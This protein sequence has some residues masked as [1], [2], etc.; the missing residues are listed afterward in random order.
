MVEL[1]DLDMHACPC[2][3]VMLVRH[4]SFAKGGTQARPSSANNALLFFPLALCER[5]G[6]RILP[7]FS[8]IMVEIY[9]MTCRF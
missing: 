7:C 1:L 8:G 3:N 6:A 2:I 4:D 5:E 9:A